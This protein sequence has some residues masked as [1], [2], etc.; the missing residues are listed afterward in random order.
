MNSTATHPNRLPLITTVYAAIW[1]LFLADWMW[2]QFL[3]W[4]LSIGNLALNP[5]YWI[6]FVGCLPLCWIWAR[7]TRQPLQQDI[8]TT[9]IVFSVIYVFLWQFSVFACDQLVWDTVRTW[10]ARCGTAGL[11]LIGLAWAIWYIDLAAFGIELQKRE[12]NDERATSGTIDEDSNEE[13]LSNPLD[14]TAWYYHITFFDWSLLFALGIIAFFGVVNF[15]ALRAVDPS[16]M[17]SLI[18]V[19]AIPG[20]LLVWRAQRLYSDRKL[21]IA[22]PAQRKLNQS[23]STICSYSFA[24][25]LAFLLFTQIG[26]CRELYEM[27]SGGGE[28]QTIAQTVKVQKIIKKKYVVN[29]FSAILFQ[30]PPIDEVKLQLQEITKHQYVVGYGEGTGAGYA[31]GTKRGKVRFIRLEYTGGDWDQDFGIGADLNMLIEYG[32]RTN[33][34]VANK[35]ESR[36]VGQLKNFPIGK[37]PPVVYLTGQ[38]NI[39]MS[40]NEIKILR[41]YITEKHGMVFGDNGGSRHFHNQFVSM[42][43][44]VLPNVRPVPVPLDDLIH[45]VPYQIPF[46][47]Y[48]APHGGKEA[49]GWKVDGRWVCYY[50]PGD[51]GDAWTDDHSGVKPEIYEFCYQLGVNVI[52]YGHAEYSKWLQA[53]TKK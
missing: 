6:V 19:A 26:G 31:G 44:K 48:V 1:A 36:T 51:I 13:R 43:R 9:A 25:T 18:C 34:K 23:L 14:L 50:H 17:L 10:L 22:A 24:F 33:Q 40:K 47:P 45:R 27:P 53:R 7:W 37:S 46:L 39:I 32:T 21:R 3:N 38:K 49:L 15:E 41:E 30:V 4:T 11:F 16:A 35:T 29:P 2:L 42:M 28:Q 8:V 20:A 5:I 52:N 12:E